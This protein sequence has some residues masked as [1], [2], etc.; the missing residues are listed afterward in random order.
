MA[1]SSALCRA[2]ALAFSTFL[3]FFPDRGAAG[4]LVGYNTELA[5]VPLAFLLTPALA[6]RD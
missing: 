3:A 1:F 5:A 2:Y 6:F 4:P